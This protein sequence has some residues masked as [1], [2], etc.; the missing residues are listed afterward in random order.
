M[1]YEKR[2]CSDCGVL[3]SVSILSGTKTRCTEC[4]S[5]FMQH[6]KKRNTSKEKE[7]VD[8]DKITTHDRQIDSDFTKRG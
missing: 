8:N 4:H 3:C 1:T 5:Y 6:G 7:A 2:K